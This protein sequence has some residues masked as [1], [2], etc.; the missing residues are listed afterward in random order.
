M[1]AELGPIKAKEEPVSGFLS[2]SVSADY[3]AYSSLGPHTPCQSTCFCFYLSKTSW[4]AL[5]PRPAL[6][7]IVHG[8]FGQKG[9]R[10]PLSSL[11]SSEPRMG[12]SSLQ[13]GLD[14]CLHVIFI[15]L[16]KADLR[17][18][19]ELHVSDSC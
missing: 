1:L 2:M 3:E 18:L 11:I 14:G 7:I 16:E 12:A 8:A 6:V 10:E 9:C 15:H 13:W 19:W 17:V 4:W 5:R